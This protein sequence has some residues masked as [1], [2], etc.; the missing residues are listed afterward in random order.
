MVV[1][2][3]VPATKIPATGRPLL[4]ADGAGRSLCECGKEV[5]AWLSFAICEH[6]Y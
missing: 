5:R 4:Y 1:V 3:S 6:V 2:G